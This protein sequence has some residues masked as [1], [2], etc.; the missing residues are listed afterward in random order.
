M[1]YSGN[2]TVTEPFPQVTPPMPVITE[3]PRPS[4]L[5]SAALHVAWQAVNALRLSGAAQ[6]G[7]YQPNEHEI[8]TEALNKPLAEG[9]AMLVPLL[10][11]QYF[12][13]LE[14]RVIEEVLGRNGERFWSGFV[15]RRFDGEYLQG[16][17]LRGVISL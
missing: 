5:G 3:L 11:Q 2:N 1:F 17:T 13:Q 12:P 7:I 10:L 15:P 8:I 6:G 4:N 16:W 9:L 14:Q